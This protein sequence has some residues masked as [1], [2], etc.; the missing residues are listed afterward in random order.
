MVSENMYTLDRI[1]DGY[2]VFLKQPEEKEQIILPITA[3][4]KS[5]CEGDIVTIEEKDDV[6]HIEILLEQ[7]ME[8]KNNVADILEQLRDRS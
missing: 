4:D 2:A 5:I 8:Q 7:T 1:E 3:L 6:Y